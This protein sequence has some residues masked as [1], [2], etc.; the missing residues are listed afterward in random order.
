MCRRSNEAN[1]PC[2]LLPFS[3]DPVFVATVLPGELC[4]D[5]NRMLWCDVSVNDFTLSLIGHFVNHRPPDFEV[6]T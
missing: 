3:V 6:Y 4:P 1:D 5:S 2:F